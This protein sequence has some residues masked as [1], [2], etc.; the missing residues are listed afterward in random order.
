MADI[1]EFTDISDS[2]CTPDE[3]DCIEDFKLDVKILNRKRRNT[4]LTFNPLECVQEFIEFDPVNQRTGYRKLS[5]HYAGTVN[6]SKRRKSDTNSLKLDQ[7]GAQARFLTS[8]DEPADSSSKQ[9]VADYDN[10]VQDS[11]D[12]RSTTENIEE[13]SNNENNKIV[14]EK[15]VKRQPII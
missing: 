6:A 3:Y 1:R 9:T 15:E 4:V 12:Q 8:I 5:E 7:F 11:I 2:D 13:D 14:E 10:K